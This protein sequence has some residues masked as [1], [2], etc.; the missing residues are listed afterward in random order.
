M[1]AGTRSASRCA[2]ALALCALALTACGEKQEPAGPTPPQRFN[3]ALDFYVN[4]DHAGV[5]TALDHGYFEQ[6]GLDVVPRVP[7]DPSAPIKQVAAGQADVAISYEP[8][9]FLARQQGLDVISV[10][11]LVD[12]PLTSL[13]SLPDAAI[14]EPADLAGK[15]IATAGIPYQQDF[16][17]T[18]LTQAGLSLSDV[19]EV[20]VGFNLLPALLGGQADAILGG[21]RNVEGVELELRGDDPSVVPVDQFGVPTYD[22]LVV[23]A[24]RSRVEDDPESIRL[25]LEA[26]AKGTRDAVK[27]PH[28]ATSTILDHGQA[29]DRE[30]TAAE[31]NATLPLL[32]ASKD[33]FGRMN[34]D[35]W[36]RFAGWMADHGLIDAIPPMDEVLTNDLLPQP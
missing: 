35:E 26:L 17:E 31:I 3:L 36:E 11:A 10:A 6:A 8:E 12:E 23:V 33:G 15:T 30:T 5:Y 25:F 16:L 27:D 19:E 28:Q 20:N 9:V 22:E 2:A 1:S 29:L 32:A 7:G 34:P 18:I 4:P 24:D 21:F 13:I 14:A